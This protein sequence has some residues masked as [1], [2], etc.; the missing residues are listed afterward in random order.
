MKKNDANVVDFVKWAVAVLLFMLALFGMFV[1]V[2]ACSATED[3]VE[4][5][6]VELNADDV[7]LI[8]QVVVA[9]ALNQPYAGKFYVIDTILNRVD[10][11]KFPSTIEGVVKQPNQYV[12][13]GKDVPKEILMIVEAE[14]LKRTNEEVLY[15]R[16]K[17]YHTFGTPIINIGDHY[18][19]K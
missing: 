13:S 7:K 14:M 10:N 8:G 18:F 17:H 9:E 12:R 6:V 11:E 19:S 4:E 5:A 1:N 3:D 16:N 2:K 15:F